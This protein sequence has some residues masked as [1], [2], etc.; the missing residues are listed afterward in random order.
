MSAALL[1]GWRQES[2]SRLLVKTVSRYLQD[3]EHRR[4]FEEW[5]FQTYGKK[6]EWKKRRNE[7]CVPIA[8]SD[9]GH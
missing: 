9:R 6:Y 5:Y 2:M 7:K 8:A 4:E 1:E 3:K